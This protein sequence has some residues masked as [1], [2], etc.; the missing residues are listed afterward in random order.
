VEFETAT[1]YLRRA[2]NGAHYWATNYGHC[3]C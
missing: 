3:G 1:L 2:K